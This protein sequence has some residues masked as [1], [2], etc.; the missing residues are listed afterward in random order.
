[1][2]SRS[3]ILQKITKNLKF[4]KKKMKK[5]NIF[6]KNFGKFSKSKNRNFSKIFFGQK[7]YFAVLVRPNYIDLHS[8]LTQ[9]RKKKFLIFWT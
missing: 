8:F 1:M 3:K 2:G 4:L 5:F 9:N 6:L 7:N